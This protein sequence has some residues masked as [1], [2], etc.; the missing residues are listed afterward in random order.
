MVLDTAHPK[1][2][3]SDQHKQAQTPELVQHRQD[4]HGLEAAKRTELGDERISRPA[5]VPTTQRFRL[6][7]FVKQ[8]T[9]STQTD[10]SRAAH[11]R[12]LHR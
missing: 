8:R 10:A 4:A 6:F 12:R 7:F 1:Q 3:K 2:A 5:Q 9:K 11:L